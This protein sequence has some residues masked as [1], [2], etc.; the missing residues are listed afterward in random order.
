MVDVAGGD[1]SAVVS[2]DSASTLGQR[3][4]RFSSGNAFDKDCSRSLLSG[5]MQDAPNLLPMQTAFN[6]S[7]L[8]LESPGIYR[9]VLPPGT[10]GWAA[11]NDAQVG[12][13]SGEWP[14]GYHLN[15]DGKHQVPSSQGVRNFNVGSTLPPTSS[16]SS[17]PALWGAHAGH[18]STPQVS[19]SVWPG[20]QPMAPTAGQPPVAVQTTLGKRVRPDSCRP[21]A[22]VWPSK[23]LRTDDSKS[24]SAWPILGKDQSE[25]HT[26]GTT[27]R[28]FQ[29]KLE[30]AIACET[31]D[32]FLN[33][34]FT[35]V[36]VARPVPFQVTI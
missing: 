36:T 28:L 5:Q 6:P 32:S 16:W 29:P 9:S 2:P 26:G 23:A 27:L 7:I 13:H 8:Q 24:F 20:G 3:L 19:T 14:H 4:A 35:A 18:V 31:K 22:C 21:E 10:S 33:R 12:F 11:G 1:A 30:L 17:A 15:L 34:H 25:M